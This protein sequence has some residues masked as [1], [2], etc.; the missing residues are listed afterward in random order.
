MTPEAAWRWLAQGGFAHDGLGQ[1]T[2]ETDDPPSLKQVLWKLTDTKR[3]WSLDTLN[4]LTLNLDNVD[5]EVLPI[6][7]EGKVVR[8]A[9][10]VRGQDRLI[11]TGHFK[12]L[13]EVLARES[14]LSKIVERIKRYCA[15]G[16]DGQQPSLRQVME[17]LEAMINEGWVVG[18]CD[19]N[20]PCLALGRL[21]HEDQVHWD[22]SDANEHSP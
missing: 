21:E 16:G 3:E 20:K 12:M 9:H 8:E 5:Q 22:E 13:A 14:D 19:T 7:M 4:V 1:P 10:W 2:T 17:S 15:D 6:F 11:L 18:S